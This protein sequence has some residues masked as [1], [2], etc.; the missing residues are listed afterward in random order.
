MKPLFFH[1]DVAKDIKDAFNWYEDK[2]KGLGNSFINE[3]EIAYDRVSQ[4]PNSW[5]NFEYGFKR[6]ILP[7]FPFS[8]IYK[9][10]IDKIFI[11]T[12]MHNRQKPDYWMERIL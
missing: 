8:V 3:L 11:V 5:L 4:M 9:E 7:R 1:P 2:A 12:V 10:E 6:Y